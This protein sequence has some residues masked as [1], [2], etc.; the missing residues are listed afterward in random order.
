MSYPTESDRLALG[1]ANDHDQSTGPARA[2]GTRT[3]RRV[4]WASAVDEDEHNPES[5]AVS[6]HELDEAGL[7]VCTFSFL[8]PF[9]IFLFFSAAHCL[10]DAHTCSR[11]PPSL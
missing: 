6:N 7:D 9:L 5:E 3:P 11:T 10:P 1:S 2:P 4:Q 8:L